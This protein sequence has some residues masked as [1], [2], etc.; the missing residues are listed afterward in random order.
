MD[1]II[2]LSISFKYSLD[3]CREIVSQAKDYRMGEGYFGHTETNPVI[4][5]DS[6][7]GCPMKTFAIRVLEV[8]PHSATVERLF[9]R[10]AYIKDKWLNRMHKETLTGLPKL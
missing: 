8:I 1:K 10:L 9:S 2:K 5:W 3:M 6:V 4:F 7:P